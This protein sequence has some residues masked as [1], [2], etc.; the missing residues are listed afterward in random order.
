MNKAVIF[1][2]DGTLLDTIKDIHVSINTLAERFGY[3]QITIEQTTK[4]IN[5]G[6]RELIKKCLPKNVEGEEFENAFE[7]YKSIYQNSGYVHTCPF[8][9]IK[10]VLVACKRAGYKVCVCTNKQISATVQLCKQKFPDFTFDYILGI[11]DGI[12]PKPDPTATLEMLKK[13][14]VS[15]KD[16]YFIGDGDTD[17]LTSINANIKGISVLW[18]YRNKQEL[19]NVGATVFANSPL[20]LFKLLAL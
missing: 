14:N 7:T 4:A 3:P 15:P 1:D 6:A 11:D 12:I 8:T 16:A 13:I 20:D 10:E 17:V 5:T 9:G 19:S 18:G 2:L